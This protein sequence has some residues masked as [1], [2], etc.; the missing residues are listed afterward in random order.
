MNFRA[1]L[2]LPKTAGSAQTHKSMS[3]IW[4]VWSTLYV[5]LWI[6]PGNIMIDTNY[7]HICSET[8]NPNPIRWR[9][10][11]DLDFPSHKKEEK[12]RIFFLNDTLINTKTVYTYEWI[13]TRSFIARNSLNIPHT[14]SLFR[15]KLGF[16]TFSGENQFHNYA[17]GSKILSAF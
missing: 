6:K 15:R 9:W 13:S 5:Y 2:V 14:T 10:G 11:F 7:R 1:V 3:C 4:I 17:T 8:S 12:S 16:C